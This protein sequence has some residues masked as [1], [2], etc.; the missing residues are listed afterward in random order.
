MATRDEI[1]RKFGPI[2]TEAIM[3]VLLEEINELRNNQGM[4]ERTEQWIIDSLA[5]HTSELL[6]Y[7][8][9]DL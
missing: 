6:P 5:N 3:L 1:F 7:D 2:L 9:M 4:P 8:W